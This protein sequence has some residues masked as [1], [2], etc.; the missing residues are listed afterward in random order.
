MQQA[1]EDEDD[2]SRCVTADLPYCAGRVG[3]PGHDAYGVT[4]T[5]EVPDRVSDRLDSGRLR[6]VR[7]TADLTNS[8]ASRLAPPTRAPSTSGW[9][10]IAGDVVSLDR[11]AVEDADTVGHV[12]AVQLGQRA[13]IAPQT[14][15]ASSG[16]AT[17]PV[18]IAQTGS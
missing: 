6:R 13:R 14:S 3:R 5:Y 4:T 12:A 15:C 7:E 9:A 16:V 11:A 1:R 8:S 2:G 10:M 18:P 17:S